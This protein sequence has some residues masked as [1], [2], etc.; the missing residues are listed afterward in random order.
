MQFPNF[1]TWV[2]RVL[3]P[4]DT[5]W[6]DFRTPAWYQH[7]R[8]KARICNALAPGDILEVGVRFGY[9]G[10]AFF[11][12]CP[13]LRRYTGVDGNDPKFGGWVRPTLGVAQEMLAREFDREPR[14]REFVEADT[15][16][17]G[18]LLIRLPNPH[19]W[20]LVYVDADHSY[21]GAL[22]DLRLFW[23]MTERVMWV[24]DYDNPDVRRAVDEFAVEVGALKFVMPSA[25]GEAL[26]FK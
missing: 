19:I 10:H 20:D 26:L 3:A 6:W 2:E 7:Y 9:S 23:Q 15:H 21:A 12:A 25:R 18:Q 17:V 5:L 8:D 14:L 13:N 22:Q 24:D 1:S 4:E 11:S 16:D